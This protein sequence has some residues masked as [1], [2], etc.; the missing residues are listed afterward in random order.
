VGRF[1]VRVKYGAVV[2]ALWV[3]LAISAASASPL[4]DPTAKIEVG[5]QS[6]FVLPAAG[7]IW[8][9]DLALGRVVR[10]DPATN[11]V[12]ARISFGLRPFGMAYGAGSLW[13]ADRSG[14]VI[15]RIDL[16]TKK[17][18]PRRSRSATAPTASSTRPAAS[19]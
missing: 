2:G 16:R 17:N 8:T 15:G 1:A 14:D 5:A 7:S 4:A 9:T 10:V 11:T 12:S 13:V 19:G 6:G 18:V 3:L